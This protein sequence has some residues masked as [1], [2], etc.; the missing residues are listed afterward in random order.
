MTGESALEHPLK[1]LIIAAG[2]LAIWRP[3]E[4]EME[5]ASSEIKTRPLPDKPSIA[6]LPFTNLSGDPKQDYLSDGI[7]ESLITRL[8]RHPPEH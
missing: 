7:T 2:G 3:W 8:A 4:P 6:V 5:P 1:R